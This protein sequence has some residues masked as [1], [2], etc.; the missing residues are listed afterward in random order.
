VVDTQIGPKVKRQIDKRGWD[1]ALIFDTIANPNRTVPC[2]DNRHLPDGNM[3][4][5]PAAPFIRSD[6]SYVVRNDRTGDIV[7]V[8]DRKDFGWGR[9]MGQEMKQ[10]SP[11]ELP[12]DANIRPTLRWRNADLFSPADAAEMLDG[13]E[14]RGV[15][16]L[17]IEG[18]R[19]G[20]DRCFPDPTAI[21]DYSTLAQAR[22]RSRRSIDAARKFIR[23]FAQRDMLFEFELQE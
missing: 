16:V 18:F 5:E 19:I 13:C 20:N 2:R 8:S 22:D 6:R 1:E 3:L 17:G 10:G 12:P 21:A 7:Q 23:S 14:K 15:T 11:R 4:D 9:P